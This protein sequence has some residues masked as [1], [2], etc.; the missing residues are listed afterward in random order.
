MQNWT[1]SK[2][3]HKDSFGYDRGDMVTETRQFDS[4]EAA[5]AYGRDINARHNELAYHITGVFLDSR[6]FI[7]FDMSEIYDAHDLGNVEW[8][9]PTPEAA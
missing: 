5:D 7:C 3:F 1:V 4:F 6:N 8:K 2:S 9:E